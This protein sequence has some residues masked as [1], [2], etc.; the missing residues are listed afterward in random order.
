MENQSSNIENN[1]YLPSSL[2][3]DIDFDE[4]DEKVVKNETNYYSHQ[5]K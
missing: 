2:L 5:E 4:L 1:K 3:N